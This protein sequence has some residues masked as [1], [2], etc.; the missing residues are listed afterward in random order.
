MKKY[1]ILA[2]NDDGIDSPAFLSFLSALR[3]AEYCQELRYV[4][5]T[6]EHSWIAQAAT[7][8]KPVFVTKHT[9]E[10]SFLCSGTPADC[11]S[12]GIGNLFKSPPDFIVSGINIGSNAGLAYYLSSG[13]VGAGRQGFLHGI[14]ALCFSVK[15]PA[16]IFQAWGRHDLSLLSKFSADWKR[17]A[18]RCASIASLLMQNFQAPFVDLFSVNLP[19]MFDESTPCILTH[20]QRNHYLPLFEERH[21]GEYIHRPKG[22]LETEYVEADQCM[23][24]ADRVVV[25]R[26]AI[27]ITP[28]RYDLAPRQEY[29]TALR[30]VLQ[31]KGC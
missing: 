10:H 12:L 14:P 7:P 9:E 6:E 22:L 31:N 17:I 26:N 24:E 30:E 16:E 8:K 27:S 15:T 29:V 25:E 11:I 3:A 5:P 1:T 13:T 28:I 21:P 4:A 2:S 20:L 23:L 19:W 18:E